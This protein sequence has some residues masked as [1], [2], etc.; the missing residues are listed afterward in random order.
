MHI[1]N[2]GQHHHIWI[3]RFKGAILKEGNECALEHS[4]HFAVHLP[5]A[6]LDSFQILPNKGIPVYNV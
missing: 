4:F 2:S 3:V 6:H 1:N 5:H